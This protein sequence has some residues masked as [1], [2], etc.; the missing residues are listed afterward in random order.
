[1]ILWPVILAG[2]SFEGFNLLDPTI[3]FEDARAH[4]VEVVGAEVDWASKV[5]RATLICCRVTGPIKVA[6]LVARG[7]TRML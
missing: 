7:L 6:R 4:Y 1:M 3:T 2:G 5:I